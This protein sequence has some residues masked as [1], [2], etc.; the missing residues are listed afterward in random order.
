MIQREPLVP[1]VKSCTSLLIVHYK[2]CHMGV[3]LKV[4]AT[5]TYP[6]PHLYITHIMHYFCDRVQAQNTTLLP[7]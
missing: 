2:N 7:I 5:F 1:I 6:Y 4:K 3:V